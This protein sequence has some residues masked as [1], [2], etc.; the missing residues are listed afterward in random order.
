MNMHVSMRVSMSVSLRASM[1][2]SGRLQGSDIQGGFE[3]NY[4]RVKNYRRTISVA[5]KLSAGLKN[6]RR[7]GA[8]YR[9]D[10]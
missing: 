8:F 2:A 4:K 1:G 5:L 10:G 3:Q 7:V 9:R 6:R